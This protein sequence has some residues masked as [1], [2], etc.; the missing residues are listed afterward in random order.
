MVSLRL[1]LY[2]TVTYS[3]SRISLAR[4]RKLVIA[5]QIRGRMTDVSKL[6]KDSK[7]T[8]PAKLSHIRFDSLHLY[9]AANLH[10][11]PL[12]PASTTFA[13]AITN[14]IFA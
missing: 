2:A 14:L 10:F 11:S 13:I 1:N 4:V 8:V 12:S 6:A 5:W 7:N 3:R 9:L